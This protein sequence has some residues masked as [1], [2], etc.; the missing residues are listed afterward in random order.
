MKKKIVW[1]VAIA[2][3]IVAAA[4]MYPDVARYMKIRAM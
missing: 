3:A 1:G 2:L 4:K